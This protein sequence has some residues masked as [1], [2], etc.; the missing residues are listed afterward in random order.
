MAAP[1]P[2]FVGGSFPPYANVQ[3]LYRSVNWYPEAAQR[4]GS[5][6]SLI[7]TPGYS[8]WLDLPSGPGRGIFYQDGRAFAISGP[9][10]CEIFPQQTFVVR[11][12]VNVDANP[13][14]I[15]SNGNEQ[16]HQIFIVSGGSG[17][18]FDLLT[19]AFT[20]VSTQTE[21]PFPAVSGFYLDG[22]FGAIRQNSPQFSLS[23]L[24]DGTLWNISQGGTQ[25]LSLTVDDIQNGAAI[26][27][28][29]WFV[30]SKNTEVWADIGAADFPLAPIPGTLPRWGTAAVYSL[31]AIDNALMCV[32]SNDD[33]SLEVIRADG[34][35]WKVVSTP[36]ISNLLRRA[37]SVA[38]ARAWAYSQQGHAFYLLYVPG[39][40][41]TPVYDVTTDLWHER[42]LYD[43]KYM[44]YVPDLGVAHAYAFGKHLVQD[45]QSGAIYEMSLDHYEM[46]VILT[47]VNP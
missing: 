25:Q 22:Y 28:K 41:T 23:N 27:G 40:E 1:I 45:R 30:G 17:Y 12:V 26:N 18:I 46:D 3:G 44:R 13:G 2:N 47:S 7:N 14:S 9:L 42:G 34:Y 15:S 43:Q 16:G 36:S 6:A 8:L 33:G 24:F 29:V 31:A 37:P 32:G 21:F 20:D 11:G 5:V 39:L 38:G 19:S 35:D 10:F 4:T